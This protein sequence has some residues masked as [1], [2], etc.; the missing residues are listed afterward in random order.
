VEKMIGPGAVSI[1]EIL[2]SKKDVNEFLIAKKMNLTI[3]QIRNI[4]YKLSAEGLVSFIRKK[5][6]RKGWYIYF[7]TL[8]TQ[9]CLI[10]IEND[11][12]NEIGELKVLLESRETRRFYTCKTCNLELAEEKALEHNFL[13]EECAGLY[14]L[15]DNTQTIKELTNKI[16]RKERDLNLVKTELKS[17]EEAESKRKSIKQKKIKN[18]KRKAVKKSKAKISKKSAVKQKKK[19]K[20]ILKIF[21][22]VMKKHWKRR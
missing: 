4:L 1:V 20:K 13:C 3:N 2:D 21:N 5:D 22:S 8:N 16:S 12:L 7:W 11:L 6:K 19:G 14:D 17:L 9:K 15:A 10:K 18:E